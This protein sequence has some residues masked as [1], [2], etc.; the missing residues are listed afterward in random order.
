MT[1]IID[2]VSTP[3]ASTKHALIRA[4]AKRT[5]FY[6]AAKELGIQPAKMGRKSLWSGDQADAI[7]EHLIHKPPIDARNGS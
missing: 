1:F 7:R 6:L 2:G 3:L 5:S 4:A